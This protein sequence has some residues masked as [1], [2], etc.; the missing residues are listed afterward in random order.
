MSL[1]ILLMPVALLMGA[2][3]LGAFIWGAADGQFDDLETPA[4]RILLA[5]SIEGEKTSCPKQR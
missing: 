1:V 3:F 4:H 5:D 2:G